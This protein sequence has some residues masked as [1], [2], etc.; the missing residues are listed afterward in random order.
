MRIS[1]RS[2]RASDVFNYS[3][4]MR[5]DIKYFVVYTCEPDCS[6][7][8][9]MLV[10]IRQTFQIRAIFFVFSSFLSIQDGP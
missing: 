2:Q 8:M 5:D 1:D 3:C 10:L 4:G 6:K 7:Q 9:E